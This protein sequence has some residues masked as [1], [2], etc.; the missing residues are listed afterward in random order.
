LRLSLVTLS[1]CFVSGY[2]RFRKISVNQ[3]NK[4]TGHRVKYLKVD[5]D[6]YVEVSKEELEN[7]TA[8]FEPKKF[9]DHYEAALAELI[10]AKRNGRMIGRQSPGRARTMSSI[11][12]TRSGRA[13][14]ARRQ[15]TAR[16]RGRRSRGKRKCSCRSKESAELNVHRDAERQASGFGS[17]HACLNSPSAFR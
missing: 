12:W 7:K 6:T 1:G 3:I 14:V 15:A 5:T 9:E 8:D 10:N 16:N 17:R 4:K 11:L 13:S 2:V